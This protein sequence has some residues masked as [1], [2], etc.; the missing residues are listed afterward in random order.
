MSGSQATFAPIDKIEPLC[1]FLWHSSYIHYQCVNREN[2]DG[3]WDFVSD[4]IWVTFMCRN[5][6]N[7]NWTSA[8]AT[9]LNTDQNPSHHIL[10]IWEPVQVSSVVKQITGI[11][12][13]WRGKGT[14]SVW[15]IH[16]VLCLFNCYN[17]LAAWYQD[18]PSYWHLYLNLTWPKA[19]LLN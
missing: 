18:S 17:T 14:R 2:T 7:R 8:N 10:Q 4:L 5:T 1:F 12:S 9:N 15:T 16:N 6:P 3:I 11:P 13:T 19:N